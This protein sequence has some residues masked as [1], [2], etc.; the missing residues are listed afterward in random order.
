[1]RTFK[2]FLCLCLTMGISACK[3]DDSELWNRLNSLEDRIETIE[4][5]L[6]QLNVDLT[7]ISTIVTALQ[8]GITITNIQENPDGYIITFSDGK[9]ITIKHGKDGTN[10]TDGI[11][12]K[13]APV[14]GIDLHEGIYYWTQTINGKTSW[15][16]DQ[17]G[18]KIPVSGKDA[19]TPRLKIS[20][21]GYW[22][23]SYDNGISYTYITDE[24]GNPITAIGKN[25]QNGEDGKDGID[26]DSFFS[27]V[28]IDNDQLILTLTDG[29]EISIPINPQTDNVVQIEG[30][31]AIV[32]VNALTDGQDLTSILQ[33]AKKE[34][35]TTFIL[36]GSYSK[37]NISS[38]NNPFK[39]AQ[40]NSLDLS[41]IT[42]WPE[43]ST[44]TQTKSDVLKGVPSDL[45]A[46]LETE[47]SFLKK[48]TLPNEVQIIGARAFKNCTNLSEVIMPGVL[49]VD[50]ESFQGCFNLATVD[51]PLLQKIGH[52]AFTDCDDWESIY[53]PS[54]QIVGEDAFYACDKKLKEVNMPEAITLVEDCFADCSYLEKVNFP[55]VETIGPGCFKYA[56]CEG[57]IANIAFPAAKNIAENAFYDC[58]KVESI[59][60]PQAISLGDFIFHNCYMLTTIKLTS[61]N[62]I[63][64]SYGTF[65]DFDTTLC[66]LVLNTNKKSE[67]N[68]NTWRGKNWKEINYIE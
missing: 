40:I 28:Q 50:T 47:E 45:F 59:N 11:D 20:P 46:C 14:I 55:K 53:L 10:G 12:G 38:T 32:N 66:T 64:I 30:E 23:V 56:F 7:S 65:D 49:I 16:T 19:I 2:L 27:N 48:I 37:L 17:N 60:L 31:N 3:Y 25:G 9:Q 67:V 44:N 22:M 29:T 8:E 51:A 34:G 4:E 13:D 6:T 43:V 24:N 61:P 26:G 52:Y 68:G 41:G 35:A 33:E 42:E 58:E 54:V 57:K 36:T 1:M 21:D 63:F 62:E 5:Q 18:N 15:L 39:D